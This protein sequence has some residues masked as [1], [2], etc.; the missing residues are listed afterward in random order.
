M[1]ILYILSFSQHVLP[2]RQ[3]HLNLAT[4]RH[5]GSISVY[6]SLFDPNDTDGWNVWT[7]YVRI[8]GN[9]ELLFKLMILNT[10]TVEHMWIQAKS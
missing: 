5:R 9:V 2:I 4:E 1:H 8:V 3:S 7:Q 10:H 6:F